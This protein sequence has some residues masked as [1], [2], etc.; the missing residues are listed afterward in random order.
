MSE[1][2]LAIEFYTCEHDE[3]PGQYEHQ[4]IYKSD[5]LEITFELFFEEERF[6]DFERLLQSMKK[7]KIYAFDTGKRSTVQIITINGTTEI[8][9][10]NY[11]TKNG[12]RIA[13]ELKNE[14]CIEAFEDYVKNVRV[15]K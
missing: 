3:Y 7:D 6:R 2:K 1:N 9:L 13:I 8:E 5:S 11:D 12:G 15:K 4:F 10:V 14:Q